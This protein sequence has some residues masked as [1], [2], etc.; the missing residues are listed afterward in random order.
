MTNTPFADAKSTEERDKRH[1]GHNGAHFNGHGNRDDINAAIGKKHG[2][3]NQ[4]AEDRPG[5]ADRGNLLRKMTPE[6]WRILHD[7]IQDARAYTSKKVVVQKAIPAPDKF[8]L[9]A[10]HPEHQH[11]HDDV[12]DVLSGMQEHVGEGLPDAQRFPATWDKTKPHFKFVLGRAARINMDEFLEDEN[13]EIG[14]KEILHRAGDIRHE[15]PYQ[16]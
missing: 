5:R 2:A 7:K 3:G 12:Q 13:T 1:D 14:D 15:K 9:A 16:V 11:V 4:N 6:K 10:E 8:Q